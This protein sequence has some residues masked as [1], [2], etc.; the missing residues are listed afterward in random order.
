MFFRNNGLYSISVCSS[1]ASRKC[2]GKEDGEVLQAFTAQVRKLAVR[3]FI[4][5]IYLE[6]LVSEGT[7]RNCGRD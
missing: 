4:L 3:S 5:Y 6:V 1:S 7:D 2:S